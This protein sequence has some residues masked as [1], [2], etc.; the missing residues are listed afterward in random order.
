MRLLILLSFFAITAC[1]TE[2]E[3]VV[4]MTPSCSASYQEWPLKD[5]RIAF[6]L[7]SAVVTCED[8][9]GMPRPRCF[10][11]GRDW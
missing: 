1:D 10:W 9:V 6:Q 3:K 5:G 8:I 4:T 11:R 7:K 2:R